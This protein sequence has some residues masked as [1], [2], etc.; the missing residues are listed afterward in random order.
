MRDIG[1]RLTMAALAQLSGR[2]DEDARRLH[3]RGL[4][5][6]QQRHAMQRLANAGSSPQTIA[7]A[8]GL[9]IEQ[10]REALA[11]GKSPMNGDRR[12]A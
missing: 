5:P 3:F 11:D 8:T 2:D 7:R 10:V 6:E 4:G 12:N 9:T 1:G